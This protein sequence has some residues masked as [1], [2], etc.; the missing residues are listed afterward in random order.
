MKTSLCYLG[1]LGA[2]CL[3]APLGRAADNSATPPAP[4][5]VESTDTKSA[6]AQNNTPRVNPTPNPEPA[7]QPGD[8]SSVKVYQVQDQ[9]GAP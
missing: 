6:A 8:T 5:T 3:V 7:S 1:V 4:G 2:V 9:P